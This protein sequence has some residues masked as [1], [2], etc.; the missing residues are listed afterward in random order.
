M[1]TIKDNRKL[2]NLKDSLN[3]IGLV[4][5]WVIILIVI[6]AT[7]GGILIWLPIRTQH[8]TWRSHQSGC[9]GKWINC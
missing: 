9:G 5:G 7:V 8:R 2:S 3:D 1:I 6:L 4:R